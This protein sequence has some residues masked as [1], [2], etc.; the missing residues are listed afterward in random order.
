MHTVFSMQ[1]RVLPEQMSLSAGCEYTVLLL[2]CSCYSYALCSV[3]RCIHHV[4]MLRHAPTCLNKHLGA[5]S[6]QYLAASYR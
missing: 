1:V 4:S 6:C 5:T 2:C 3:C